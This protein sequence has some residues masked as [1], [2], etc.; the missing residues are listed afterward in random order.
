MKGKY[1][2]RGQGVIEYAVV[3]VVILVIA[4]IVL[5]PFMAAIG[6]LVEQFVDSLQDLVSLANGKG[7]LADV[8]T[9]K[10]HGDDKHGEALAAE[11]RHCIDNGGF[12]QTWYNPQTKH[13]VEVCM[14]LDPS[15][16][17]FD[18]EHF[19]LRPCIDDPECGFTELTTF[20][21]EGTAN[22]VEWYLGGQGYMD[23]TPP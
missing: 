16:E 20:D 8:D 1:S 5:L 18:D 4:Y 21:M 3:G 14:M 10:S 13:Y 7:R 15:G 11:V 17:G 2:E 9:S 6:P 12:I 23:I 22:D 19:G